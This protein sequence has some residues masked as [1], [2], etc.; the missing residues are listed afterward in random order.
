MSKSE[1]GKE[2]GYD[3]GKKIRDRSDTIF[4]SFEG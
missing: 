3:S 4:L 2:I 1:S